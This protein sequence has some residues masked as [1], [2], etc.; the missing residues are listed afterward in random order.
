[1][2]EDTQKVNA[3]VTRRIKPTASRRALDLETL[4]TRKI[5]TK[6]LAPGDIDQLFSR[7]QGFMSAFARLNEA[8]SLDQLYDK[9]T[10]AIGALFSMS[11]FTVVRRRPNGKFQT[12]KISKETKE[13]EKDQTDS[14]HETIIEMVAWAFDSKQ[15][16]FF[17]A[18]DLFETEGSGTIGIIPVSGD[19]THHMAIVFWCGDK[20]ARM[21]VLQV[22]MLYALGRDLAL[23][24]STLLQREQ[25]LQLS[26]LFDNII[27]SVPHAIVAISGDDRVV[28]L[29]ANAE[30]LFDVKRI[31]A[32]DE[33]YKEAFPEALVEVF[34]NLIA[35]SLMAGVG[36]ADTEI[37][38]DINGTMISAGISL[39][40]L[41][42]REGKPQGHLFLC[43][44]LSLSRE[45]QKLRELD[46]LKSEFVNTV[47]HELKTPLT[48]ILG[49]LEVLED[50][51]AAMDEDTRELMEVVQSGAFRLRDLIFDLLDVSRL[52]AG[53]INLKEAPTA[54][55]DVIA[56]ALKVQH[57]HPNHQIVVDVDDGLPEIFMDKAK[58]VQCVTNFVS[59]AIKYSPDG[60]EVRVKAT[61]NNITRMMVVSVS[62]QGLGIAP[63][64]Q[65]KVW[66]K[67]YRVDAG[68]TQDIEGTG[69]GLVIVKRI[70][71][72]HGGVVW[73]ESEVGKGS[74]F[75]LSLP[76]KKS[77]GE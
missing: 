32:M 1:M 55:A 73:I 35:Q 64:H 29:N 23:R 50:D 56:D 28:A 13:A 26:S 69:L 42:D 75:C 67:F 39:N 71:E 30:F 3:G 76:L 46:Q 44:D 51:I 9:A 10:D 40:L 20:V 2:E 18:A 7:L 63:E 68:Y 72:L 53:R 27:E 70:V 36:L 74:T 38:L 25:L 54:I 8:T 21:N 6:S 52:E 43:R 61:K 62:D 14:V 24:A 58:V 33:P 41:R 15:V 66:E 12:W 17:D 77:A 49:G 22:D 34:D 11:R 5:D 4:R 60:G 37:D 19:N 48:A 31:F 57:P 47:S 16:M 65:K 59:N 45:V